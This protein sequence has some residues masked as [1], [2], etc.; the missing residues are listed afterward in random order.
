[1]KIKVLNF[2][3]LLREVEQLQ[4]TPAPTHPP[5]SF[6]IPIMSSIPRFGSVVHSGLPFQ[7]SDF[8][9]GWKENNEMRPKLQRTV[10]IGE[11]RKWC[12][13]RGF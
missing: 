1:M 10:R 7:I 4:P 3:D 5:I 9:S 2:V 12:L 6:I 13:L 11:Q 8:C